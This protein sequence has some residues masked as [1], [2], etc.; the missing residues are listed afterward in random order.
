MYDRSLIVL[1]ERDSPRDQLVVTLYLLIVFGLLL[2]AG[3]K[4]RMRKAGIEASLPWNTTSERWQW[5]VRDGLLWS[6]YTPLSAQLPSSSPGFPS[7]RPTVW[8]LAMGTA[9]VENLGTTMF[10]F[11]D[12]DL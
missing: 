10:P 6:S 1:V 12:H 5:Q 3:I 2:G 4:S 9:A 11:L 7:E 8:K